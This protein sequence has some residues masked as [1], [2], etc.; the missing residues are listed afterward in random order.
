MSWVNLLFES[1]NLFRISRGP[2]SDKEKELVTLVG[3]HF[4]LHK[5]S[6]NDR[7][8]LSYCTIQGLS[9]N[10]KVDNLPLILE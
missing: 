10:I 4:T 6:I 1:I 5:C 2:L 8:V 3:V 9:Q 7:Q